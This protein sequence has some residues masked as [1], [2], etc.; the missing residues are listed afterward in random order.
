M[1]NRIGRCITAGLL[2][3][4]LTVSA[5]FVM[6]DHPGT[7]M[8]AAAEQQIEYGSGTITKDGTN[9]RSGPSTVDAKL[10]T[11]N[12]GDVVTLLSIPVVVDSNHWYEV[13]FNTTHGYVQAPFVR[14]VTPGSLA[15]PSGVTTDTNIYCKLTLTSARLRETPNGTAIQTWLPADGILKLA[16]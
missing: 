3:A 13:L 12:K 6:V 9:L 11:L 10:T 8:V 16:G 15:T 7:M 1:K 2:C 14:I 4:A 5:S